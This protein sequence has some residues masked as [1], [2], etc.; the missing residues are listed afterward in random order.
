MT[1]YI[2]IP[3]PHPN[4][5]SPFFTRSEMNNSF[6]VIPSGNQTWLAGKFPIYDLPG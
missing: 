3:F 6:L 5:K 4:A 1:I 2:Y